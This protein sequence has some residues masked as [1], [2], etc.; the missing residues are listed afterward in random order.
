MKALRSILV[1]MLLLTAASV[2]GAGTAGAAPPEKPRDCRGAGTIVNTGTFPNI[3]S[4]IS[5]RFICTHV[6]VVSN[7]AVQLSAFDFPPV[8]CITD[9][10]GPGIHVTRTLDQTVSAPDGSTVTFEQ[11][12][13][14]LC[15]SISPQTGKVTNSG[16]NVQH[17][18]GTGRFEGPVCRVDSFT[19][20]LDFDTNPISFVTTNHSV[21]CL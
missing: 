17:G 9:A 3:I 2:V 19:Q 12:S 11:T 20:T 1:V 21:S 18:L 6:G 8:P 10:G 4:T 7:D 13:E 15:Q 16:T 14:S 5:S